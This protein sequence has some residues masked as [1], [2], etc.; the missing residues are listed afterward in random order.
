M[1]YIYQKDYSIINIVH[2]LIS[3]G[4]KSAMEHD[5]AG[6][7]HGLHHLPLGG[8][9]VAKGLRDRFGMCPAVCDRFPGSMDRWELELFRK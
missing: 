7:H 6:Q 5:G 2:E 9:F 1:D 4:E 8:G 3:H